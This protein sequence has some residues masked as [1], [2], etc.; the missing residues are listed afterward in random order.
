[1]LIKCGLNGVS[2]L[3][4]TEPASGSVAIEAAPQGRALRSCI[5]TE[6]RRGCGMWSVVLRKQLGH[7]DSQCLREREG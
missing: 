2:Y 7:C 1:M 5:L 6:K 3:K 4:L